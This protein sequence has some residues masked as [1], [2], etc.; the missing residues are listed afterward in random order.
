M[1]PDQMPV[2]ADPVL[3]ETVLGDVLVN[4]RAVFTGKMRRI[5][6]KL[7]K[8]LKISCKEDCQAISGSSAAASG[9]KDTTCSNGNREYREYIEDA[10]LFKS[11]LMPLPG[12]FLQKPEKR[13]QQPGTLYC[14]ADSGTTRR[15]I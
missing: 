6:V 13:R 10:E 2:G 8:K 1:L 12:G 4:A 3:M 11:V 15:W 14:A 7:Y 5:C 9:P